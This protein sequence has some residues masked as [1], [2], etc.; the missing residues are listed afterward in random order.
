MTKISL[1]PIKWLKYSKPK[2]TK[3]PLKIFKITKIS[4]TSENDLN[5]PET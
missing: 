1:K 5:D 3:I 4:L 2:M